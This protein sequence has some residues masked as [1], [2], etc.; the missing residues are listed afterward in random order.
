MK[1]PPRSRCNATVL[2]MASRK[3]SHMYD[4]ALAPIG[5]KATQLSLLA[6]LARRKGKPYTLKELADSLVM[7]RSTIGQ[8]I[9][10]LERDRYVKTDRDAEDGRN[11]LV[12]LTVDG[13]SI[14]TQGLKIWGSV[15]E[16]FELAVGKAESEALRGVLAALIENES[17]RT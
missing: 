1:I 14:L 9:R 5:L 6:E 11:R 16:K 12:R 17:L 3:L 15:Q 7:D 13:E 4:V 2:R 10:P 8:N